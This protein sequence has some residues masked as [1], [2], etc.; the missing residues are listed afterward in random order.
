MEGNAGNAVSGAQQ[1]AESPLLCGPAMQLIVSAST[2]QPK[3]ATSTLTPDAPRRA[4][5]RAAE[6]NRAAKITLSIVGCGLV[7]GTSAVLLWY[8]CNSRWYK[9]DQAGVNR[10]AVE[11]SKEGAFVTDWD[12]K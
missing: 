11:M 5:P 4:L 7:G 8:F 1:A 2:S 10:R 12:L 9:K 3:T 6:L